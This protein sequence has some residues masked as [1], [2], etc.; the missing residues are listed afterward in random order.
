MLAI[1]LTLPFL[2]NG[3]LAVPAG[4]TREQA[5]RLECVAA[6][7][8][9]ASE[10]RRQAP[11]WADYRP[12]DR[13]GRRY[14]QIVVDTLAR[15]TGRKPAEL[16]DSVVAAIARFQKSGQAA[17][18]RERAD[19]CLADLERTVPALPPPPLPRCAA[20][21]AFARD[22][23]SRREGMTGPVKD[24]SIFASVLEDRART[25]LRAAGKTEGEGDIVLGLEREA[26]RKA[27]SQ[28]SPPD[29]A[30][31]DCLELARP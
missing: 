6:Y 2:T 4:L 9:I 18:V 28:G 26:L 20:L 1:V 5:G 25:E 30:L 8:I 23:A 31:E 11:E 16:R 14:S 3:A 12:L 7:A 15:E 29:L 17:A 21:V 13:D 10:Q 22:D 27:F 24:L 19:I